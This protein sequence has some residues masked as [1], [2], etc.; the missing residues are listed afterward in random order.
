MLSHLLGAANEVTFSP[1][2]AASW[3]SS[4]APQIVQVILNLSSN[5]LDAMPNGGRLHVSTRNT[6]QPPVAAPAAAAK[7]R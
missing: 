5:S 7:I 4:D 1:Q 6:G 2:A 3:I